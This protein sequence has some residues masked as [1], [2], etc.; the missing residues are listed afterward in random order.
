MD[1]GLDDAWAEWRDR[2][3][4]EGLV[5]HRGSEDRLLAEICRLERT[6]QTA[7][8]RSDAAFLRRVLALEFVEIGASGRWWNRRQIL[9]LLGSETE[10]DEPIEVLNLHARELAAGV[11]QTFW[12]SRRGTTSA[13]RTSLWCRRDDRWVI[14]F[15]QG[16]PAPLVHPAG[17]VESEGPG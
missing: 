8:G 4:R 12:T 17:R 10:D 6:L 16:T 15:H 14:V 2:R 7:E 1:I 9:D 5:P 13:H 3:R 11:V